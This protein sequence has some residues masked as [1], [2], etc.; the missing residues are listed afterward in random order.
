MSTHH[1]NRITRGEESRGWPTY[2]HLPENP[3]RPVT[4]WD[5]SIIR[6]EENSGWPTYQHPPENLP[7]PDT[8]WGASG[9]NL[10]SMGNSSLP[11]QPSRHDPANTDADQLRSSN[12]RWGFR[13][14]RSV[15]P[16][17]FPTTSPLASPFSP[18][19]FRITQPTGNFVWDEVHAQ[20]EGVCLE[21]I[22][23]PNRAFEMVNGGDERILTR[24]GVPD[25]KLHITV[26]VFFF[27]RL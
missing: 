8:T 7:R 18:I 19:L 11:H 4:I 24:Y 6:G 23:N 5:A 21:A 14:R 2:Q 22:T 13:T 10:P 15:N 25:R 9:Y 12:E 1:R 17:P 16:Y 3:R 26:E 27:S 20:N